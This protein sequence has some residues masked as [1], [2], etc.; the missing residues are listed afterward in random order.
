MMDGAPVPGQPYAAGPA[1]G[2]PAPPMAFG[3]PDYPTNWPPAPPIDYPPQGEAPLP[4][5]PD[6][7]P[8]AMPAPPAMPEWLRQRMARE[9]PDS[10]AFA[11]MRL[12]QH[13]GDEAYTLDIDLNG[14]DPARVQVVPAGSA[15]VIVAE[16]SAQIERNETFDDGRGFR[17]S[18]SWTGGSRMRRLPVP[19]DGDLGAM[20]REDSDGGILIV[21]PRL[22]AVSAVPGP[23]PAQQP[24]QPSDQTPEPR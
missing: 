19:P 14:L 1:M 9:R 6:F 18:Y 12:T 8:Y 10:F 15:L 22:A 5:Q 24:A 4:S 21:I 20:L 16:R 2:Y 17:R 23:Q 3:N 7:A 11:G 13:R